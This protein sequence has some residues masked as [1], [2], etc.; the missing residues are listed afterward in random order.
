[1]GD[2]YSIT[3]DSFTSENP[4]K[5]VFLKQ[6]TYEDMTISAIKLSGSFEARFEHNLRKPRRIFS[7]FLWFAQY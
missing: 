1:M 4:K 7:D 3:C 5:Y 2:V 6:P